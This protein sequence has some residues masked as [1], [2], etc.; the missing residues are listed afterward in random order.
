MD[1]TGFHTHEGMLEETIWAADPLHVKSNDLAIRLFIALPQKGRG[2][3]SGHLLL[4]VHDDMKQ[5]LLDM[6]NFPLDYGNKAITT[7]S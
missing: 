1:V 4:K 2:C 3:N 5:F 7:L 6:N